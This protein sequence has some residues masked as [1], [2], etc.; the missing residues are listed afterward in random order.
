MR[1]S[2]TELSEMINLGEK[3]AK[4]KKLKKRALLED[5]KLPRSSPANY[6]IK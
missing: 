3:N 1:V 2:R 4:T 5:R 6:L